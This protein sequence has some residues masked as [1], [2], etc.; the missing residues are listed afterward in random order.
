MPSLGVHCLRHDSLTLPALQSL[1]RS[2][3]CD[4]CSTDYHD[5]TQRLRV[6]YSVAQYGAVRRS[7][8]QCGA[9]RCSAV[10]HTLMRMQCGGTH[11]DKKRI[12][13]SLVMHQ[14]LQLSGD[15]GDVGTE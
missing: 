14:L 11:L 1:A 15:R 3:A 10:V 9:V 2:L 4:P 8:A 7:A 13:E 5:Q 12:P 6:Q